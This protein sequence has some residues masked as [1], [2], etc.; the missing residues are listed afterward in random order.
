MQRD[1]FP[2]PTEEL[3]REWGEYIYEKLRPPKPKK[4]EEPKKN[5][6]ENMKKKK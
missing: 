3:L 1:H 6:I 5:P 4:V 2:G